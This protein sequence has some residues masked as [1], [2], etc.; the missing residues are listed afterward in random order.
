MSGN[1]STVQRFPTLIAT[2]FCFTMCNSFGNCQPSQSSEPDWVRTGKSQYNWSWLARKFDLNGD[3]LVTQEEIPLTIE[4]FSRLDRDWD[5]VLTEVDFR[6][7]KESVLGTQKETT[8]AL[9]KQ[10]D[11]NSN[12]ELEGEEWLALFKRVSSEEGPIN[13]EVLEELIYRPRVEKA[14][15]EVA[16][17]TGNSEY[18]PGSLAAVVV[19]QPGD[20]APDFELS[21]PSSEH[22]I[23][24]SQYQGEKPVVLVF[25]C[26]TCGNYRTYSK[27]L[28]NMYRF[29]K[30]D[31]EF[32]RVY[33]REAHPTTKEQVGTSTNQ[34]A[35]ILFEQPKSFAE[36]CEVASKFASTMDVSTP[37]VVDGINNSVGLL[38]GAWPDRLYIVDRAGKIA[39]TG[40]PGPFGFN[41]REMEQNLIMLLLDQGSAE[42]KSVH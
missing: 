33:V 22:S 20:V 16:L 35:G 11:V 17:R 4:V 23:R 19:P 10:A 14:K 28:E 2:L 41:P 15:R 5:G 36:R 37:M 12:G 3:Q 26:Y 6:W 1:M 29:W 25:G 9:F 39:Y 31:V 30:N 42:S 24:L 21:D 7:E 13:E 8:F 40:G 34:R 32:L 18:S 38:Y 27:S